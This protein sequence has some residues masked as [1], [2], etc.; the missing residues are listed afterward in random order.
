MSLI[1]VN[2]S[3]LHP[4]H[5]SSVNLDNIDKTLEKL[6]IEPGAAE[7]RSVNAYHCATSLNAHLCLFS[8][9]A[10]PSNILFLSLMGTMVHTSCSSTGIADGTTR[11]FRFRFRT[12][13]PFGGHEV[14]ALTGGLLKFGMLFQIA[15]DF[16]E[17][18]DVD[19]SKSLA[20]SRTGMAELFGLQLRARSRFSGTRTSSIESI[21]LAGAGCDD[22][23]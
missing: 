13:W 23:T 8:F 16:N 18:D 11:T 20:M 1:Y 7:F 21:S 2:K 12:G 6:G 9:S 4:V 22:V 15:E 5:C 10:S 17:L 14:V 3:L 19:G